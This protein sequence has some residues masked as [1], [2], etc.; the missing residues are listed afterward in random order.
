MYTE[1]LT[2][3]DFLVNWLFPACQDYF[4]LKETGDDQDS[5]DG[6]QHQGQEDDEGEE[7]TEGK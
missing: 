6:E 2:Y 1:I 7:R 3:L 4:A 5:Q